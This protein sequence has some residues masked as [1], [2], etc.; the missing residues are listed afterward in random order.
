M[1]LALF[2]EALTLPGVAFEWNEE[3]QSLVVED[4]RVAGVTT[5]NLR[6]G[7]ERTLL[8]PH[9][10]LATG[11]FEGNLERVLEYWR[12]DLPKPDR[13]LLGASI[14]ATGTGHDL[15]EEA[16]A[17][18]TWMNR[19]Y[20][21]TN[22]MVRPPG[23]R[24]ER[25]PLPRETMQRSGSILRV[26]VSPTKRAT[27]RPSW[28]TFST[29]SRRPTGRFSMNRRGI[30]SP[31]GGASGSTIPSK[32][33]SSSTIPRRRSGRSRWSSWPR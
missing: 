32:A 15:A 30:R 17:G 14:H 16:G 7:V 23:I 20:I 26:G 27:T 31:C 5:R 6:T 24:R 2:R 3:V 12:T 21:Y 25:S 8:A 18:L 11:G 33:I 4:G 10:V 29:R 19:H 28:R 22:G 1:V 13:L 9:V